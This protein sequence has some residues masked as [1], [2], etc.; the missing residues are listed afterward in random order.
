MCMTHL[1]SEYILSSTRLP[2]N[3]LITRVPSFLIFGFNMETPYKMGKRVL[4]GNL[5]NSRFPSSPLI[6]RAPFFLLFGFNKGTQK[7]KG[8]KGTTQQ[9]RIL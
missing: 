9:P 1:I 3:H 4:L 8:Q 5:V 2:S 6:I 7:E